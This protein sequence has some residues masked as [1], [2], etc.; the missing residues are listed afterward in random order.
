MSAGLLAT[1][2][3]GAMITGASDDEIT[4]N[5][6]TYLIDAETDKLFVYHRRMREDANYIIQRVYTTWKSSRTCSIQSTFHNLLFK[7]YQIVNDVWGAVI[8]AAHNELKRG[9]AGFYTH[10]LYPYV[11]LYLGAKESDVAAKKYICYHPVNGKQISDMGYIR[12]WIQER[13]PNSRQRYWR[14]NI[15]SERPYALLFVNP[16]LGEQ[17]IAA[18]W[19]PGSRVRGGHWY[20]DPDRA[21]NWYTLYKPTHGTLSAAD[22][23]IVAAKRGC[24]RGTGHTK[25]PHCVIGTRYVSRLPFF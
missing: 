22:R 12:T 1:T 25:A 20:L 5:G 7:K 9:C 24:M 10:E 14:S 23:H 15:C 4:I 6:R 18:G 19:Q 17:N 21:L 8:L 13:S 2:Y 11:A 3:I 16:E